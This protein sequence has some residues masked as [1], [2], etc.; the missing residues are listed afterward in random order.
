M[1]TDS[2]LKE[3]AAAVQDCVN[4]FLEQIVIIGALAANALITSQHHHVRIPLGPRPGINP[5]TSK[6]F[7]QLTTHPRLPHF[8]S[9]SVL[10]SF[11]NTLGRLPIALD[12]PPHRASQYH[13]P[14][15]PH[16]RLLWRTQLSSLRSRLTPG[17]FSFSHSYVHGMCYWRCFRDA[18]C[19][20]VVQSGAW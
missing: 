9:R 5:T 10:P 19:G 4:V 16:R 18:R 11:S 8:V 3:V 12:T 7:L 2:E 17:M 13:Q 15:S 6:L 1:F 14:Q 20:V